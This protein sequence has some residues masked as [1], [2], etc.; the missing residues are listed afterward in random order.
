MLFYRNSDKDEESDND[1]LMTEGMNPGQREQGEAN[2]IY[3][4][5][6]L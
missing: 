6:F 1:D 3:N 2:L 5:R 4:C